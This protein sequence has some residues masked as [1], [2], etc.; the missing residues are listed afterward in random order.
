MSQSKTSGASGGSGSGTNGNGNG[1][2]S[3]FNRGRSGPNLTLSDMMPEDLQRAM[4]AVL[5]TGA[6]LS[7][8]RTSDGG[9]IGVYLTRDGDRFKEWCSTPDELAATFQSLK[10]W[11]DSMT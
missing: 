10:D 2:A 4:D 5:D 9:A 3:P 1:A 6:L 7:V 8:G 11:A